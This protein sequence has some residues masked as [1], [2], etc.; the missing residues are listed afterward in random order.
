MIHH[1]ER[2]LGCA[3]QGLGG[4]GDAVLFGLIHPVEGRLPG[5]TLQGGVVFQDS[6]TGKLLGLL[7]IGHMLCAA[8]ILHIDGGGNCHDQH[9]YSDGNKK[10]GRR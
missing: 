4:F 6:I 8:A 2:I 5:I 10:Q 7:Q 1:I 3:A 9:W